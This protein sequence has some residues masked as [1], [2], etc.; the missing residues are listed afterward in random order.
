LALRRILLAGM[1][2]LVVGF[3][4]PVQAGQDPPAAESAVSAEALSEPSTGE[5]SPT[6]GATAALATE[7]SGP[8]GDDAGAGG[9]GADESAGAAGN[10][11]QSGVAPQ[12]G[13]EES[14]GDAVVTPQTAG[15]A[16]TT[17]AGA[18]GM[19][20]YFVLLL[21]LAVT[22]LPFFLGGAWAR[23]LRMPDYGWKIGLVLASVASATAIT[24]LGWPPQLGTDLSGGVNLIYEV[25]PEAREKM[26]AVNMDRLIA[27][28]S[29]RVN[30][31]GVKEVTVRQYGDEQVEIIIPRA[32][33]GE[34]EL[35]KRQ[36]S[37]AGSLEFRITA[38]TFDHK[39]VIP[40]AEAQ[41]AEGKRTVT[42]DGREVARWVR[43]NRR[44]FDPLRDT[45]LVTRQNDRGEWEVLVIMDPQNVTGDLLVSAT[46]GV[47]DRGRP[48]VNFMFDNR[49][50][51]RF[52]RLTRA[53]LPVRATNF[54]R[55]LGIVL[56]NELRSAPQINDVITQY[57]QISGNFDQAEVD[58]L[59]SILNAGSLPAAL[60]KE[61]ISE[62]TVSA[63]MGADTV[64]QGSRAIAVSMVAVLIFMIVYY[65]VAGLVACGALL[66]NLV[67]IL[68]VMITIKAAFTLPGI[69]GLVLTV[70]MAV[71]ANVLIYER[72]REELNRGASL[73]MAIRNGFD[74]ATHTIVD[75]NV[76]TLITAVVLY[77]IGTDQ[78]RGFAVTLFLGIIMSMFTA[79][80]CSRIF[81]D[82]A[83]QKR[84]IRQLRMMHVFGQTNFDF[85]GVKHAAYALSAL[86]I[87]VGM[88]AVFARRTDML[89]ID[90]TG[91]SSVTLLFQSD[92]PLEIA[93][94]RK[95]VSNQ[96]G[97][98]D[99]AVVGVGEENVRFK[100]N[101]RNRD[102]QEVQ[103]R[104]R[105]VFGDRLQM[106][107]LDFE[108]LRPIGAAE[109]PNAGQAEASTVVSADVYQGGAQATLVT[110]EPVKHETLVQLLDAALEAADHAG[111]RF[112]LQNPAYQAGSEARF[113][114]W[115]LKMALSP[116]EADKI[117]KAVHDQAGTLPVFP[118][119]SNIGGQVAGDTQ[120]Q[121]G[122]AILGSMTA[123]VA[124]LWL[125][126]QRVM[127]G[128]A[129]V[130][131]VVHDV[132][133]T[134][135]A[136][137]LSSYIVEF[138][139]PLAGLLQIDPFKISL[140]IIAALMTIIG[141]SLNDTI[142]IFDRI[143]DVKGK[144]PRLT[145]EI[146][147]A[148]VN[149]TLSRTILTAV[150]TLIVVVILFFM[151]GSGIHGF[152]FS[153]LV[154]VVV[155]TYS[156]VYIASPILLWMSGSGPRTSSKR[157]VEQPVRAVG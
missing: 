151:G 57:G 19:P 124:Y 108:N 100:I 146:I 52:G 51:T 88:I 118:S 73:R 32:D 25:D 59:I 128:L 58:F 22:V 5:P 139:P 38:N 127:Y 26:E 115:D 44:E 98:E 97:L 62:E 27:A 144:L 74:R 134:I 9:T 37:T 29:Q 104:L 99:V 77:W 36:I 64:E 138:T 20:W 135:G 153:L 114:R 60:N 93:E 103:Q 141:Y 42:Q 83:E 46:S 61:P 6:D 84:W 123:I 131:A 142:V 28:I 34:I 66:A 143:R 10:G 109:T 113:D 8:A 76:T 95:A 155:G 94:V 31:S 54:Y 56:D 48:A 90:F 116:E 129:A 49:G 136:V 45:H 150:T 79:V 18:T 156:S 85:L 15:A 106:N 7:S 71:D 4:R 111:I 21:L 157:S 133:V 16:A 96:S 119:S 11:P 33:E 91:G 149:Q 30:P 81:F 50:A 112:E 75:A 148:S 41:R 121:A 140:P 68:A 70:G 35:I 65:R 80:F 17:P 92:K 137:A 72:I 89:D 43:L 39:G 110:G 67:L 55:H 122:Y 87:V 13:A 120:A 102:I 14:A 126:F 132:L 1:M 2:V 12:G 101:T 24:V 147:N 63:T 117:L 145:P 86:L 40:L 130:A 154:G 47:D 23:R 125:R 82:I 78:V 152:A 3:A 69:A 107:S 105:A 53:N